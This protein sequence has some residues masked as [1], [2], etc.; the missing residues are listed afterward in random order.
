MP[1]SDF[2]TTQE[3]PSLP[4]EEQ[5][6]AA[7]LAENADSIRNL[8]K[9]VIADV[10]EIG[11]RL[12][13]CKKLLPHGSWLPWLER[14]FRWGERTARNFISA[15]ELSKSANIADL[16]IGVSSVYLLAAPSTPEQ[17]RV[18]VLRRAEAGEA[19]SRAEIKRMIDE[20][21][22]LRAAGGTAK[23]RSSTKEIIKECYGDFA[24]LPLIEQQKILEKPLENLDLATAD[25]TTRQQW[26]PPYRQLNDALDAL[27][28]MT[29][30]STKKI[31]GSIPDEH[32]NS[33][34]ARVKRANDFLQKIDGRLQHDKDESKS[35]AADDAARLRELLTEARKADVKEFGRPHY[36]RII[37]A[38]SSQ[39][40]PAQIML[41]QSG[42]FGRTVK[43][44]A[45]GLTRAGRLS[46]SR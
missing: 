44:I 8:S 36:A 20:T 2:S 3:F 25:A 23:R 14:E 22:K 7:V 33:T 31:I 1:S 27:E 45:E 34:A 41:L 10:I 43:A 29:K 40:S 9:R 39:L 17:A 46:E 42:Q 11:G 24:R 18:E 16:A 37:K 35:S 19:L 6:H 15:F 5:P 32:I 4:D 12:S 13:E 30:W 28:S 26:K 38:I 21:S